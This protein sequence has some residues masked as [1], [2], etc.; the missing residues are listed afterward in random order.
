MRDIKLARA[1]DELAMGFEDCEIQIM[2]SSE[3][4]SLRRKHRQVAREE[5]EKAL[6]EQA[7][8]CFTDS[9]RP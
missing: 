6:A 8:S 5:I 3:L 7:G 2:N 1:I 9:R 4:H